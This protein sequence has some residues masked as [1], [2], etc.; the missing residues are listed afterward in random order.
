MSWRPRLV[1]L[2]ATIALS[3]PTVAEGARPGRESLVAR[4]HD[5]RVRAAMGSYCWEEQRG[6]LCVDVA[7]PIGYSPP[8]PLPIHGNGRIEL[9]P[10][11]KPK[12]IVVTLLT[13]GE[14]EVDRRRA[15][16]IES[17]R[18]RLRLPDDVMSAR[19]ALVRVQYAQGTVP[20]ELG[21]RPHRHSR[22]PR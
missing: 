22:R 11:G 4:S 18:W 15:R 14:N 12:R 9:R 17:R 20:F 6:S 7:R 21:L 5:H 3:L 2:A 16:R 13:E 19:T 1:L 8:G 10:G